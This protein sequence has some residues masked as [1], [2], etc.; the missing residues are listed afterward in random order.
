LGLIKLVCDRFGGTFHRQKWVRTVLSAPVRFP[1][2]EN[3]RHPLRSK[4]RDRFCP[5]GTHR[6]SVDFCRK[7]FDAAS[8][9]Q[10]ITPPIGGRPRLPAFCGTPAG[11]ITVASISKVKFCLRE[12]GVNRLIL[13]QNTLCFE[14]GLCVFITGGASQFFNALNRRSLKEKVA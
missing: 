13:F 10:I 5:L 3:R 12:S 1:A 7:I 8:L 4:K 9:P 14:S 6:F 11:K 2:R